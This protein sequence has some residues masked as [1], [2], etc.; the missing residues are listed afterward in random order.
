MWA[1][2]RTMSIA[3]YSLA[4]QDDVL[5]FRWEIVHLTA[6]RFLIEK[7]NIMYYVSTA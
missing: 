7:L 6:W 1:R 2:A 3:D 5:V 4:T